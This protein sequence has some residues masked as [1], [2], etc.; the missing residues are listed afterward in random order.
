[1]AEDYY[2][3]LGVN[4]N[5]SQPDIEK[6]HR[7]L[8][9]KYH[10]DINPNDA[11]AEKK[12]Q[13]VQQAYD[14]LSDTSKREMYD[15]YGSAFEQRG[16]GGPG[17]AGFEDMDWSQLFGGGGPGGGAGPGGPDGMGGFEDIFKHFTQGGAGPRQSTRRP[18]KGQDVAHELTVPFHTAVLGGEAHVSIRRP[19]GKTESIQA[20]IPA[21]IESGKKIRLRGQGEP[22]PNGGKPG[23]I[24]V[25]IRAAPHPH[26]QRSGKNLTV[27]VPITLS[28]AL[29]GAKIDVPTPN[30]TGSLTVPAGAS[31]GQKLRI[32]GQGVK[33]SDGSGD[34]IVELKVVLPKNPQLSDEEI[35]A[36]SRIEEE[37]EASPREELRW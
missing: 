11:A 23:D 26:F 4:R 14:V 33:S 32:K 25:T 20:K 10:P 28:E 13:E 34:L 3:I 6:A 5:A 30:G 12:F 1:M 16:G 18:V 31:S 19:N 17:G 8:A 7:K 27:K 21:G 24:L 37:Y 2:K 22:S 36:I 35:A 9:H 29:L 15:R